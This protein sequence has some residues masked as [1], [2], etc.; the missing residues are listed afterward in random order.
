MDVAQNNVPQGIVPLDLRIVHDEAIVEVAG[1]VCKRRRI[2]VRLIR[3][4]H[5]RGCALVSF[6]ELISRFEL[7]YSSRIVMFESISQSLKHLAQ[8]MFLFQ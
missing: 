6:I 3:I 4:S 2:H 5:R 7:R 1:I 8:E